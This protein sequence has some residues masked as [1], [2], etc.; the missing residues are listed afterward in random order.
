M[1]V[2]DYHYRFRTPRVCFRSTGLAASDDAVRRSTVTSSI[3][4]SSNSLTPHDL[5]ELTI[6]TPRVHSR[7]AI[8]TVCSDRGGSKVRNHQSSPL[9]QPSRHG[10]LRRPAAK[11]SPTSGDCL[12]VQSSFI[13][14]LATPINRS[15]LASRPRSRNAIWC[16]ASCPC[17]VLCGATLVSSFPHLVYCSC[18]CLLC[19]LYTHSIFS[20]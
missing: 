8:C 1:S 16:A 13:P 4:R 15:R 2:T 6:D 10:F 11:L 7:R 17:A 5:A 9:A 18:S 3:S 12:L 14:E 20:G 19:L